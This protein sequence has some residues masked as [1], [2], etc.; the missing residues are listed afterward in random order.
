MAGHWSILKHSGTTI[1]FWNDVRKILRSC[2]ICGEE[3][4]RLIH[5]QEFLFPGQE[6][7]AHYD[8]VAC[9][10]CGFVFASDIPEQASLNDFYQAAEHHLHATH[11]PDG[12]R[13]IHADFFD[14]IQRYAPSSA[15]TRIMDIGCGMGH[16]LNHFKAAGFH[17]LLGV[18]PSP[19]AA[20]LAL[21][22][23][24]IDVVPDTIDNY[25]TD[26]TY[27]LLTLC[28]VL[29]HIADL[30]T[31][32]GKIAALLDPDGTLLI[33]VPDAAMFGH[34]PP[35]EPFLEFALE[36]INF[37][38]QD[39]LDHLLMRH[40]LQRVHCETHWNEF[41]RNH[42]ILGLY[43]RAT[44]PSSTRHY[45]RDST[46]ADSVE[47]YVAMSRQRLAETID[48]IEPLIE[49]Q[50][51]LVIWGAGSLT[52]RL[53]CTTPL[54]QANIATIIDRNMQLQGKRLGGIP[55]C[56]PSSITRHEGAAVFI[57]ST[58]YA[59]E[60]SDELST[61]DGWTGRIITLPASL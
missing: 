38:S 16:F 19:A 5:R 21:A 14:F 13:A 55:I 29:E 44:E 49:S 47:L 3:R 25:L 51:P 33:A 22:L 18:E 39:S 60:I 4:H 54:R 42:Y 46:C 58:S 50:Q 36:H 2:A 41:Y 37:F 35:H 40:G 24:G 32:M 59:K 48:L 17:R 27:D 30:D 61:E 7:E 57:A 52:A 31:A 9:E 34:E 8:V 1:R 11:L 12:L 45:E 26:E 23:Y 56:P 53:M 43:R 10:M 28:G 20:R 6:T 15:D